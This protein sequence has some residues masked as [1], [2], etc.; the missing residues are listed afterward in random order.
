[1]WCRSIL[2]QV[3]PFHQ[4]HRYFIIAEDGEGLLGGEHV[5]DP[6]SVLGHSR[7]GPW[8][9]FLC[10]PPAKGRHANHVVSSLLIHQHEWPS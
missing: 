2:L 3:G 7:V 8:V 9:S 5:L 4:D 1:M 10:T 6:V